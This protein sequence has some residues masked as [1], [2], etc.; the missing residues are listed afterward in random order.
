MQEVEISVD[1]LQEEERYCLQC[2]RTRPIIAFSRLKGKTRESKNICCECLFSKQQERHERVMTHRV[3]CQ[4]QIGQEE[5]RKQAWE[6]SSALRLTY[7]QHQRERQEWYLQQSDR[8]CRMCHQIL[9]AT[10]FG[11]TSSANG[12]VLHTRCTICH[13]ALHARRQLECCLCQVKT[14]RR[15]FLTRYD[16]YALCSDGAWISLCCKGCELAFQALTINQQRKYIH[17]CCQKA[18]PNSQIIY[19]EVDPETDEIRYVGRTS[20]P[21]RRHA[22][23]LRDISPTTCQWGAERKTWYTRGNWMHALAEKGL[24]PSM[25]ILQR[26]EISPLVVE[27]EQRSIWHGIQQGWKLLNG[28]AMD[29]ELVARVKASRL[30]FLYAPF[31]LLMQQ[32]FFSSYGLVAFLRKWYQ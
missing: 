9:P 2:Q 29:E 11:G 4:E 20:K 30:D 31:E 13:E 8:L 18:F 28:E 5:R 27:W 16:G 3:L 12:F 22:Q 14:L 26:V 10:A 6:R 21:Q 17:A 32:H 19:A 25:R 23:H 7:E 24:M 15:D 1:E